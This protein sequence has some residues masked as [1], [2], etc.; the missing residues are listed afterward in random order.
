M[1]S[2]TLESPGLRLLPLAS[3]RPAPPGQRAGL[4]RH[5]AGVGEGAAQE[6]LD[7]G[8]DATELV[9]CPPDQRVVHRRVQPD[10][11]RL[12]VPRHEYSVPAL[13]IGDGG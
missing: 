11:D 10:E 9:C 5:P 6:Q 12:A 8:V 13:T 3:P 1:V 4:F 2:T 7:L